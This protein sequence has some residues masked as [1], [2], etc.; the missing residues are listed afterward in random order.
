MLKY[1]KHIIITFILLSMIAF[2]FILNNKTNTKLEAVISNV[3]NTNNA[4][5][6]QIIVYNEHFYSLFNPKVKLI[7]FKSK[8]IPLKIKEI[9][10]DNF[11]AMLFIP[12]KNMPI[13][14]IFMK[15]FANNNPISFHFN[16]IIINDQSFYKLAAYNLTSLT[17]NDLLKEFIISLNNGSNLDFYFKNNLNEDKLNYNLSLTLPLIKSSLELVVDYDIILDN[18][19]YVDFTYAES[20]VFLNNV[21]LN[22]LNNNK[23]FFKDKILLNNEDYLII[24][25]DF[26]DKL[27]SLNNGD[28]ANIQI[29]VNNK[30]NL[31]LSELSKNI[32]PSNIGNSAGEI[33]NANKELI[34]NNLMFSVN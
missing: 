11:I 18:N 9:N 33:L 3:L 14:S 1:K 13:N 25:G 23:N 29:N 12:Q 21:T 19:D 17:N 34:D 5:S 7:N 10:I 6:D 8:S 27:K 2:A 16:E 15:Y 24:N 4:T 20:D 31:N 22:Y 30:N 28:S 26:G 32:K